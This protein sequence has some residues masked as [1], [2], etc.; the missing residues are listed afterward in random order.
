MRSDQVARIPTR[1]TR[2]PTPW[3]HTTNAATTT[4]DA[5]TNATLW[6][7]SAA[8][9]TGT[10]GPR[11]AWPGRSTLRAR[12][13]RCCSWAASAILT[14]T[15]TTDRISTATTDSTGLLPAT[16]LG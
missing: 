5:R 15:G 10:H 8:G 11:R 2:S 6:R 9:A 16:R 13:R 3:A 14:A 1:G 12:A 7:D 4:M